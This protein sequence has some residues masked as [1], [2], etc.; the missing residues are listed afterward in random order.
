MA[1]QIGAT[2]EAQGVKRAWNTGAGSISAELRA[3]A[4]QI[5]TDSRL[6]GSNVGILLN[7]FFGRYLGWPYRAN[8]GRAFD[9]TGAESLEFGSLIYTSSEGLTRVP[10]DALAC[11]IDVH[12]N[13]GLG[14]LRASYEK[15]AQAKKLAKSPIPKT[16]SNTPVA[17]A[18]MGII[19][20]VDSDVPLEKLAEELEQL[21]KQCP[22]RYW[23]DMVVVLSRGTLNYVCQ[24]P[25]QPL[26]DF[27]P[28]ARDTRERRDVRPHLRKGALCILLEQNVRTTFSVSVFLFSGHTTSPLQGNAGGLANERH[29]YRSLPSQSKKVIW[30]LFPESCVSIS[31]SASPLA[32][33]SKV[34]KVNCWPRFNICRGR[35]AELCV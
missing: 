24:F 31:F 29:D 5:I 11:A 14:E 20:A 34:G 28:P 7:V 4:A 13:L 35:M 30:Y 21:N 16:S 18:T 8:P 10:A 25:H 23:V 3:V 9:S 15:I 1:E 26:G 27:L 17:D 2:S 22:H 32:F 12:Q 19:F 33:V 6:P